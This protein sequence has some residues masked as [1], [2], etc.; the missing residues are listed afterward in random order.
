MTVLNMLLHGVKGEVIW[1]DSLSEPDSYRYRFVVN[2]YQLTYA[3]LPHYQTFKDGILNRKFGTSETAEKQ[4]VTLKKPTQT[5][6]NL[7]S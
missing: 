2:P 1:H 5:Q 4:K 7:F 3:G 6:L